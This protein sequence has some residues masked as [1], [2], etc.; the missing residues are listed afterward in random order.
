[1]AA[2]HT[3]CSQVSERRPVLGRQLIQAAS[4][5][6]PGDSAAAA[7]LLQRCPCMLP[8]KREPMGAPLCLDSLGVCLC[9]LQGWLEGSW[10]GTTVWWPSAATGGST[11]TPAGLPAWPLLHA[12]YT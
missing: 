8:A 4:G 12:V 9:C 10:L 7:Q 5:S 6:W 2:T 1:M 3:P 11:T